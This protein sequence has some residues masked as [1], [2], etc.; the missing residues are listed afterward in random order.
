MTHQLAHT[1]QIYYRPEDV[2]LRPAKDADSSPDAIRARIKQI[3]PTVPLARIRLASTPAITALTLRRDI[4]LHN[5]RAGD[6][7]IAALLPHSVRI[8]PGESP[9]TQTADA[10]S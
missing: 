3:D 6:D 10:C 9:R 5:L 4:L 2:L 7:V 8:F 1:V